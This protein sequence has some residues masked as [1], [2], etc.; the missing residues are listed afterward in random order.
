MNFLMNH[1][2]MFRGS[3]YLHLESTSEKV[4]SEV[5]QGFNNNIRWHAG[6]IL[7]VAD[8]FFGLKSVPKEYQTLFG[9]GSKPADWSGEVPSLEKLISQLREQESQAKEKIM[10]KLHEALPTAFQIRDLEIKTFG[11]VAA[12]NNVHEAMHISS[13][14]AFKRMIEGK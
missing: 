5:P 13:I 7:T 2:R 14:Q 8:A 6:H 4:A 3:L 10:P 1:F 11:E 12:F 9:P